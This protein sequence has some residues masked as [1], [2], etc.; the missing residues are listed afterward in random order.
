MFRQWFDTASSTYTYLIADPVTGRAVLIDPV[1]EQVDRDTQLMAEMGVTLRWVLETHVHADHVTAAAVLRER[2]G[3]EVGYP[4]SS[5]ADGAD[6]LLEHG[7]HVVVDGIDLEVRHTPGHTAC[8]VC[9]LEA[10]QERVFTGDTLLIR[11]CG[12]TDF[13]G[14]SAT[15]LYTSIHRQLF[16]L[17]DATLVYPAHDY[18]GRTV[19][20]IGEERGHNPRLGQGRTE[21]VFVG[22]MD[23]LNLSRPR[24]IDIAV[25]ANRRLGILP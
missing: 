1:L 16:T 11:G 14:G 19:S 18:K 24:K 7:D 15:D 2:T 25:P 3:C 9:Y 22:I 5:G 8:S 6:R 17:D 4:S 23:G 13:Q 12:R 20:T 10:S 21:S